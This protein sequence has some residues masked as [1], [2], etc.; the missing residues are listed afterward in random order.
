MQRIVVCSVFNLIVKVDS[1]CSLFSK[2]MEDLLTLI[3]NSSFLLFSFSKV[4]MAFYFLCLLCPLIPSLH[5]ENLLLR[6]QSQQTQL[7]WLFPQLTHSQ[8]FSF[9]LFKFINLLSYSVNLDLKCLVS[10]ANTDSVAPG[11]A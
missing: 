3:L 10:L 7:N 2:S 9:Q 8:D 11:L 6:K 5:S 4:C 1:S